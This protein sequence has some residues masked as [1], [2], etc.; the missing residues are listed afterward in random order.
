VCEG[1]S[2]ERQILSMFS[3]PLYTSAG[4]CREEDLGGLGLGNVLHRLSQAHA[5]VAVESLRAL[6]SASPELALRLL[7]TLSKSR[8]RLEGEELKRWVRRILETYDAHGLHRAREAIRPRASVPESAPPSREG[9]GFPD[10]HGVLLAYL[11]GLGLED[12]KLRAGNRSY[13]DA[14]T[15]FLPERID[16]FPDREANFLLYK[17]M[18]T[19]KFAQLTLGTFDLDLTGASAQ[20]GCPPGAL[21]PP[22]ALSTFL[23][24]FADPVLGRDLFQLAD[25]A[26]IEAWM[27]GSL[28]GLHREPAGLKA[29]LVA[30]RA[31][32]TN[33]PPRSLLMEGLIRRSLTGAAASDDGRGS[34]GVERAAELLSRVSWPGATAKELGEVLIRLYAIFENVPGPYEPV[35][36]VAYVGELRLEEVERARAERSRSKP[37]E[38]LGQSGR[39]PADPQ[40]E[41]ELSSPSGR[42][43]AGEEPAARRQA[44]SRLST[45]GSR[46]PPSGTERGRTGS[47]FAKQGTGLEICFTGLEVS[48]GDERESLHP[49]SELGGPESPHV[50]EGLHRLDEWDYRRG[51]YRRGWVALREIEVPCGDVLVADALLAGYRGQVRRI[52]EAFERVQAKSR[53]DRRQRDGD[54]VDL[55]AAV[56]GLAER[57]AG[58]CPSEN[59]YARLHRNERDIAAFFLV[60]LSASTRGMVNR[61]QRAAL[62]ILCEALE[63]L[64]DRFAIYGFSGRTRKGCE[65][66]RIKGL[67]ECYGGTV[68]GRIANLHPRHCTRLA[69][70]IRHLT[71]VMAPL[72]AK[73]KLLIILSDGKPYDCDGYS[74]RYG[75]EDT[76]QAILEARQ[77]RIVPFCITID[78][79]E[80][81]Y[82]GHMYGAGGY[83]F[84]D[85]VARLPPKLPQIYSRLTG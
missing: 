22:L 61:S 34:V 85:D 60:D 59:V 64:Q 9:V 62:L 20:G 32:P 41:R 5:E 72:E 63:G 36:P 37:G 46:E 28:P 56:E 14:R 2:R 73:S 19:H 76:R 77:K 48:T 12:V 71:S 10:V 80:H 39:A 78:K 26:R 67:N 6:A 33:V 50:G 30:R 35:E 75:V 18:A 52:R 4:V 25:G 1:A 81:G 82:L 3:F 16:T 29:G 74:E 24:R 8:T 17:V 49:A 38:T 84:V 44:G 70:P 54:Q 27:A 58:L 51:D 47:A 66:F 83:I 55:D 53:L 15:I 57:R 68:R 7:V 45:D 11:Q 43:A 31:R 23:R 42:E 40:Q 69:P 65:L 79:E 13:T 21:E